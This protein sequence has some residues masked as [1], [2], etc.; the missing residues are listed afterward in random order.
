MQLPTRSAASFAVGSR[1]SLGYKRCVEA[2]YVQCVSARQ[3]GD[4]VLR[5]ESCTLSEP[6]GRD[7]LSARRHVTRSGFLILGGSLF[8]EHRVRRRPCLPSSTLRRVHAAAE[9]ETRGARADP[10]PPFWR[11]KIS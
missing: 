1:A 5:D 10:P 9:L 4:F 6:I 11:P 3:I 2:V 7:H 8:A